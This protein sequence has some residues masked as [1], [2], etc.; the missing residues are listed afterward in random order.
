[1][2]LVKKYHFYAAHRNISAGIKCSRLHGHTYH[3]ELTFDFSD[4]DTWQSDGITCLFSNVDALVEPIIKKY[5]HH[6]LLWQG[7]TLCNVL[8]TAGEVF[9]GLPFETSAENL[10]RW[11]LHEVRESTKLPAVKIVLAETQSS[12]VEYDIKS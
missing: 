11:L 12:R 5:D 10:S 6:L 9:I 3:V 1:M 7:D 2:K 4:K 8:K